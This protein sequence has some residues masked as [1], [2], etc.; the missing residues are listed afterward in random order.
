MLCQ[1]A[2]KNCR[3]PSEIVDFYYFLV[4]I[5][6]KSK[7]DNIFEKDTPDFLLIYVDAPFQISENL[8]CKCKNSSEKHEILKNAN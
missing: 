7:V 8:D 2:Q 3:K 5:K 6:Q 4:Q 1:F